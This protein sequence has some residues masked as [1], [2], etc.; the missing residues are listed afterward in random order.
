MTSGG[1]FDLPVPVMLGLAK[2]ATQ[3]TGINVQR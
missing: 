2:G 3:P 1:P